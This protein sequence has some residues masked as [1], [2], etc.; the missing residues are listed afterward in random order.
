MQQHVP[1][2]NPTFKNLSEIARLLADCPSGPAVAALRRLFGDVAQWLEEGGGNFKELESAL[3]HGVLQLGCGLIE[4]VAKVMDDGAAGI[5]RDGKPWYWAGRARKRV[6]TSLGVIEYRRGCCRRRGERHQRC[7]VDERLELIDNCMT[8]SAA[9]HA[10]YLLAALSTRRVTDALARYGGM[11]PSVSMLQ[12]MAGHVGERWRLMA[13][14]AL[15]RIAADEEIPEEA[16]V[17]E[18]S[19]DGVM[20]NMLKDEEGASESGWRE[21]SCG[22]LVFHDGEGEYLH[23]ICHGHMPE[24]GKLGLKRQMTLEVERL[25]ARRPDLTFIGVADGAPDNWTWLDGLDTDHQAIDC[26]HAVQHLREAADHAG[27]PTEW[28]ERRKGVL[29]KDPRGVDK[30][31]RALR[32][33]RQRARNGTDAAALETV[34]RALR[35]FMKNR[36]RMQYSALRKAGLPIG[37]GAVEAAN[38]VLVTQRMKCSGMRWSMDGGQ[39]ILS[40]RALVESKRFDA[41]CKLLDEELRRSSANLDRPCE[42]LAAEA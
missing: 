12:R 3:R 11:Q 4:E 14:E 2:A 36:H 19:I 41:A 15:A 35:H 25:R 28:F 33:Q 42:R 22:A 27:R 5:V 10:L 6:V 1:D 32:H 34:G 20:V 29:L 21:A 13:E 9:E 17:C 30:V 23:A 8:S 7:P 40:F 38:K 31:I 39:A 16:A 24:S 37:S 26:W 18:V